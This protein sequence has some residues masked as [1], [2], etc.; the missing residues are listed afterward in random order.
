M[1]RHART[2]LV[3]ALGLAALPTGPAFANVDQLAELKRLSVDELLDVEVTSVSRAAE[4]LRTAA[5]AIAVVSREDLR[6]SGVT[7]MPEALRMVPGVHVGRQTSSAWAVSSRGFSSVTSEKLLVL[8]DTRS[9]YTPLF[10]GVLWD[11]QNYLLE[12]VERVEVIRGPG[13]SLWGSNAVNGVI[14]ITT[15][16]ARDTHG[17]YLEALGGSFDRYALGARYGGETAGGKHFRV[18]GRYFDRDATAS[19]LTDT[20]DAWHLGH[21]GFRGDWEADD[22]DTWTVQGDG[23]AGKTGEL[24]PAINII[25]RPGP[26]GRLTSDLS[27]GNLLARWR[28]RSSD[29]SDLQL[30][31]YYDVTRHDD[32][33]YLDTLQTFDLDLQQHFVLDERHDLV[34]GAAY[35]LTSHRNRRGDIFALDPEQ[36]DDNLFSGFVQ[37]RI[38]VS[39]QVELTL[40]T[41]LEH[42]D[43]SGFEVQPSL[44][45]SWAHSP[46]QVWWM[47]VS[48]AVRVPTRLERDIAIDVT[49]PAG[50]PVIRLLG[51]RDFGAERLVAY[52]TGYRWQPL[53]NLSFDL[54]LFYNDY[55]RLSSLELGDPF[56]DDDGRVIIPVVNRN[57]TRGHA[58]GAELLAE[59]QPTNYWRLSASYSGLDLRLES[60]GLDANRGVWAEGSTPRGQ[61]TLRSL[62]NIGRFEVDAQ[63]RHLTKVR[64]MPV[65]VSGEGIGA[66][67]ELDL[68]VGWRI[69]DRWRLSLVGQNLLDDQHVEFGAVSAR[70]ALRR[71]AYLKAEWRQL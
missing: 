57:L 5:A 7:S 50:N 67:S 41:K 47:A 31:A 13:A 12:D 68:R 19:P 42:N 60:A 45:L 46:E 22:G 62:L 66:Y 8:S 52:E 23:Y 26:Q 63:L 54:A 58:L 59:W 37:D 33:S 43:F 24:Q 16:S 6:R 40:G 71:A 30:R 69:S 21:V 3:F 61:A 65:E 4:G 56:L 25:G 1:V 10:S 11:V 38:S 36:S 44:R 17:G 15:R 35:R 64:R 27:G 29:R 14:N 55:D 49:D 28:H 32:A 18:F 51:N 53:G 39:E 34:W 48:R 70:G 9:I 2:S 20:D